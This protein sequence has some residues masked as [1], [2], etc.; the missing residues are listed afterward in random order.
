MKKDM[1]YRGMPFE[2]MLWKN[3]LEYHRRELAIF[4][5]YLLNKGERIQP[6]KFSELMGQ[7]H[8]YTRSVNKLLSELGADSRVM[9][10]N[11][12]MSHS[13]S[14]EASDAAPSARPGSESKYLREEFFYFEQNYRQFK[15][16]FCSFAE[17]LE[18]A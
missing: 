4:E 5:S 3:E 16:R 14:G 17:G 12:H 6:G 13:A 7:L 8:Q 10:L 11:P 15:Y 18:V 1:Q 9:P 2:S